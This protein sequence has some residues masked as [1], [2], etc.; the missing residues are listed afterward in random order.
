MVTRRTLLEWFGS[1]TGLA[2]T[3]SGSAA[4]ATT[5]APAS[6]VAPPP[7]SYAALLKQPVRWVFDDA[8]GSFEP[9]IDF[10][11][12]YDWNIPQD[13][14]DR[15]RLGLVENIGPDQLRGLELRRD[16]EQQI[17]LDVPFIAR[18][19]PDLPG[20]VLVTIHVSHWSRQPRR[21]G[22]FIRALHLDPRGV[23]MR[24]SNLRDGICR[25]ANGEDY[26]AGGPLVEGPA[27]DELAQHWI[28]RHEPAP[29]DWTAATTRDWSLRW[30]QGA[31][32]GI[33]WAAVASGWRTLSGPTCGHCD[34]PMLLWGYGRTRE[35]DGSVPAGLMAAARGCG[36]PSG[37]ALR[38]V[39]E[40]V[41][42]GC[43]KRFQEPID[44][45]D[46][47]LEAHVEPACRPAVGDAPAG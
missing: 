10:F 20:P 43:A 12:S 11:R 38:A 18:Q 23:V 17:F 9:A 28:K 30:P 44:D 45:L 37:P 2:A 41:C 35:G 39:A 31:G 22:S 24:V 25:W 14:L 29:P 27:L 19:N 26:L 34:F 3:G 36:R 47:W 8:S 42:V 46:G 4:A 7:G 21:V 40:F 15:A 32:P 33:P 13:V 16:R 5:A 6:A 1:V